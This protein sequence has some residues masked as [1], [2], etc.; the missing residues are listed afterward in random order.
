MS[1]RYLSLAFLPVLTISLLANPRA[2]ET[3]DLQPKL[4]EGQ[5]LTSTV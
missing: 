4:V 2:Q 5:K 1:N 3:Y